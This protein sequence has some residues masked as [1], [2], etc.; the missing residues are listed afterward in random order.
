MFTKIY[1]L[2]TLSYLSRMEKIEGVWRKAKGITVLELMFNS[3]SAKV[4]FKESAVSSDGIKK[5]LK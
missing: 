5:L 3:S 2:E 4:S 1:Q